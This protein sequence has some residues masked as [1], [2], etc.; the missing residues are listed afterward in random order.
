VC[1][2]SA[3]PCSFIGH[4]EG[5]SYI[6][7]NIMNEMNN[8]RNSCTC[9]LTIGDNGACPVHGADEAFSDVRKTNE[10]LER[11]IRRERW[12]L[13]GRVVLMCIAWLAVVLGFIAFCL[14]AGWV[15]L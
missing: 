11:Q 14:R 12:L 8:W 6:G 9:L 7:E 5:I 4:G 13:A 15:M 3:D 1:I 10:R 2:L